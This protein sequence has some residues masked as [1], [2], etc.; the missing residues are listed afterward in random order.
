MHPCGSAYSV[1]LLLLIASKLG[2]IN[3]DISPS[4]FSF[5][6]VDSAFDASLG[7]S[8]EIEIVAPATTVDKHE[9]E[10]SE[11]LQQP[12]EVVLGANLF[13][14]LDY[15]NW[16]MCYA[17]FAHNSSTSSHALPA[18][19]D[20]ASESSA[21]TA[22]PNGA[23]AARAKPVLPPHCVAFSVVGDGV[24]FEPIGDPSP[25]RFVGLSSTVP[26]YSAVGSMSI[27]CPSLEARNRSFFLMLCECKTRKVQCPY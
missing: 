17:V 12:F 11:P 9:K 26:Y 20:G 21:A 10:I 3:C 18:S 5:V 16:A 4:S 13:P 19:A 14:G 2:R 25:P 7:Q 27:R 15:S 1:A 24:K 22:D 8:G 23:V 6:E